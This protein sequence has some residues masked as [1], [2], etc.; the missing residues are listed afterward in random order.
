MAGISAAS[1]DMRQV[2]EGLTKWLVEQ[3]PDRTILAVSEFRTSATNGF[4]SESLMFDVALVGAHGQPSTEHLVA[5]LPPRGDGIFREYDLRRQFRVQQS[6]LSA[7]VPV[8]RQVGYCSEDSLVGAPFIVMEFVPGRIPS[9][10][11][12]YN[13]Q[14][15]LREEPARTQAKGHASVLEA[16]SRVHAVPVTP[17][18]LDVLRRP[19]GVGLAVE[20]DWYRDY[21]MWAT[22]NELPAEVSALLTWCAERL[23]P[24]DGHDVVSWGDAR[25]G[26]V[27]FRD[28]MSVAALLDWEMATACP[29]ELDIGWYLGFRAQIRARTGVTAPTELPGF[30]DREAVIA[31]YETL[32]GRPLINI[33]WFEA[34]AMLRLAGALLST[35]RL[36]RRLGI[37]DHFIFG[38]APVEQWVLDIIES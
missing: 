25:L 14:G 37:T 12:M 30:P 29:A 21:L 9:N 19:A 38:F 20:L 3:W 22:D 6:M 7:G 15:W 18:A 13:V 28:D 10:Q 17:D 33:E 36:V 34:F 31:Q 11:P 2:R 5:R 23:P 8:A 24:T 27:V 4:S 16:M 32:L 1:R 35:K 26:N